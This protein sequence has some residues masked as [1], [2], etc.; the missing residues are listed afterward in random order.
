MEVRIFLSL[1]DVF[2]NAELIYDHIISELAHVLY[3]VVICCY[4]PAA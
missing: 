2:F 3:C 1:L 4:L